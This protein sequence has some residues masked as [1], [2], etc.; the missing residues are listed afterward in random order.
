MRRGLFATGALLV[1]YALPFEL[2]NVPLVAGWAALGVVAA[3]ADT[4]LLSSTEGVE[5]EMPARNARAVVVEIVM[6]WVRPF[7]LIGAAVSAWTL[8]AAHTIFLDLRLFSDDARQLSWVERVADTPFVNNATAATLIVVAAAVTASRIAPY[9]ETR[10]AWRIGA[11]LVVA[12]LVPDQILPGPS[13]AAWMAL[14]V[15]AI[16]LAE[17]EAAAPKPYYVVT[18]GLSGLAALVT[19]LVVAPPSRLFVDSAHKVNHPFL[20]SEATLALLAIAAAA[21]FVYRRAPD[22]KH[23][24]WLAIGA[25]GALIYMMSV[26]LVDQ[27]QGQVTNTGNLESL[28]RQAQVALSILWTV[29]GVAVFVRGIMRRHIEVR[30][31]GLALLGLATAK[32]FIFDLSTLNTSYRVLSF[33]GLGL[34]LMVASYVYQRL[35]RESAPDPGNDSGPNAPGPPRIGSAP[36]V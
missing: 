7:A 34:L 23:R 24:R 4:Y 2:S 18:A 25:G 5:E 28:Q 11:M 31:A 17:R 33:V 13:V 19:V 6:D 22:F 35:V 10:V 16:M 29:S 27:F 12:V 8:A 36:G 3:A 20:W 21:V 1:T 14:A 32:V 15:A 30:V 26:G 9:L